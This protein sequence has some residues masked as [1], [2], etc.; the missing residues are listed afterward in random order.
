M[1]FYND[2]SVYIKRKLYS[3]G[4][5]WRQIAPDGVRGRIAHE[6]WLFTKLVARGLSLWAILVLL[7]RR[8]LE[9]DRAQSLFYTE[10]VARGLSL[11]AILVLLNKRHLCQKESGRRPMADCAQNFIVYEA[12]STRVKFVGYL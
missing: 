12:S 1:L 4:G 5:A 6:V 3:P 11:W 9:A 7:N 2:C 8:R 10:L